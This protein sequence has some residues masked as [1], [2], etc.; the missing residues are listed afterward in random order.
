MTEKEIRRLI[1][2]IGGQGII[3]ARDLVA[4]SANRMRVLELFLKRWGEWIT[5]DTI[6]SVGGAEGTRRARELREVGFQLIK[7]RPSMDRR[8]WLY[9]LE[10]PAEGAAADDDNPQQQDL[11]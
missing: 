6:C 1:A 11:F 3:N 4:I 7:K 8:T 10:L 5:R 9:R 2:K